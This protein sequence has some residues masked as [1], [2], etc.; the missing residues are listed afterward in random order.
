[1][2][3]YYGEMTALERAVEIAARGLKGHTDKLGR[4][5]LLHAMRLVG[6][7]EARGAGTPVLVLAAIHDVPEDSGDTA[8]V[9]AAWELAREL[10]IA[11]DLEAVTR[12]PHPEETYYEFVRRARDHGPVSRLVKELDIEDHIREAK[13]PETLGMVKTRYAKA[14][15]IARGEED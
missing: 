12:K 11:G 6:M 13:S 5:A 2:A 14:L 15:R 10:G 7:A 1:M 3:A 8:A 9:A 4:P